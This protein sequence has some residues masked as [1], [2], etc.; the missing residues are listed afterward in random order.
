M[1]IGRR[2]KTQEE[3]S[4]DLY[5]AVKTHS[6]FQM[7]DEVWAS[8]VTRIYYYQMDFT[9]EAT[10]PSLKGKLEELQQVHHTKG[11]RSLYLAVAPEYFEPIVKNLKQHLLDRSKERWQRVV[12]ENPSDGI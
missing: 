10:Y 2:D 5:Q 6:R 3:Y 9:D 11:I 4:N 8:L 1:A 12:I 7:D